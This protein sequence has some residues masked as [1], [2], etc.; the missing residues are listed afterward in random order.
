[1]R[2]LRTRSPKRLN[3]FVCGVIS[4]VAA[5]LVL[6]LAGCGQKVEMRKVNTSE[7]VKEGDKATVQA[8]LDAAGVKG[9]VI[10][11]QDEGDKWMAY[12]RESSKQESGGRPTPT[13]PRSYRIDKATGEVVSGMKGPSD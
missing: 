9:E 3:R 7:G 13:P 4:C 10:G 5:V 8:K 1:M 6:G 11:V 2:I 12:V